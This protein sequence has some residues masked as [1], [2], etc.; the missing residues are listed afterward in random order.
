MNKKIKIITIICILVLASA[1][2]L[3][4]FASDKDENIIY[5][6]NGFFGF[7]FTDS[8]GED[9]S[10]KSFEI[11]QAGNVEQ[12]DEIYAQGK[13]VTIYKYEVIRDAQINQVSDENHTVN[14]SYEKLL[15]EDVFVDKA[16]SEGIIVTDE[17]VQAA[18]AKSRENTENSINYSGFQQYVLGLGISEDEYWISVYDGKKNLLIYNK[19]LEILIEEYIENNNLDDSS[20]D[21]FVFKEDFLNGYID[22]LIEEQDMQIL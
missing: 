3:T 1:F 10:D 20:Y 11:G 7:S 19:Y 8:S 13:T 16:L 9:G 21:Y 5:T 22:E 2:C 4:S 14:D 6:E 12:T 15:R 17:E 18:I